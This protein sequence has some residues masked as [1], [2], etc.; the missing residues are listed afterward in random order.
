MLAKWFKLINFLGLLDDIVDGISG[1][2]RKVIV[3]G[4]KNARIKAAE[5]DNKFDDILM[6][7]L[8]F[9]FNVDE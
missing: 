7:L 8:C 5:T 2:L 3:E 6:D 9:I 1:E 4:L